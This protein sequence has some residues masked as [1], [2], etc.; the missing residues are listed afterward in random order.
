MTSIVAAQSCEEGGVAHEP[1]Q[2]MQDP[3]A[4]LIAVAIQ[5]SGEIGRGSVQPSALRL[6]RPKPLGGGSGHL[7][8]K[9]AVPVSMEPP[10]NCQVGRE[11]LREPHM[12]PVG[13]G[14]RVT[15]PLVRGLVGNNRFI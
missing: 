3:G 8:A 11:S 13:L 6:L 5:E 2:L 14:H 15:E 4:L 12:V 1:T 7:C 10:Q 9:G